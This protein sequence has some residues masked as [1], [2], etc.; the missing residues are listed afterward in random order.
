M[1]FSRTEYKQWGEKKIHLTRV[2]RIVLTATNQNSQLLFSLQLRVIHG[3]LVKIV[4]QIWTHSWL[5]TTTSFLSA[6]NFA[7]KKIHSCSRSH[8]SSDWNKGNLFLR[9]CFEAGAPMFSFKTPR[10]QFDK[11]CA[12][13]N[14]QT[15]PVSLPRGPC[16]RR[17]GSKAVWVVQWRRGLSSAPLEGPWAN[18]CTD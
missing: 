17:G 2:T 6:L 1:V 10:V 14:E 8:V 9:L 5:Q 15:T 12:T 11:P 3:Q 7:W 16:A 13:V 18:I 4:H